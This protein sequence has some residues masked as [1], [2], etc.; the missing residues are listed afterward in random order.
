ME[1]FDVVDLQTGEE[2]IL[3]NGWFTYLLPLFFH[4]GGA[5]SNGDGL[6]GVAPKNIKFYIR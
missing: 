2:A 4:F 3:D 6:G 5:D 1:W